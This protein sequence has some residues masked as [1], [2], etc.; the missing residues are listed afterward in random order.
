MKIYKNGRILL[1]FAAGIML[2]LAGCAGPP[3]DK[4][5]QAEELLGTAG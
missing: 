5:L 2:A 1:M 3:V 4:T